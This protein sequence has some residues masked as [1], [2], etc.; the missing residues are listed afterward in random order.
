MVK[1]ER[2]FEI[3]FEGD[4]EDAVMSFCYENGF[5]PEDLMATVLSKYEASDEEA[6]YLCKDK[7]G[8]Y[9]WLGSSM[10]I[11]GTDEHVFGPVVATVKSDVL[12]VM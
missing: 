1:V 7:E 4:T 5:A 11:A 8:N 9:S 12:E 3:E 6:L 10:V 2:L